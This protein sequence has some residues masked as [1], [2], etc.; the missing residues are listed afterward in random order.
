MRISNNI[1]IRIRNILWNLSDCSRIILAIVTY[2]YCFFHWFYIANFEWINFDIW[3][4]WMIMIHYIVRG[5]RYARD[6]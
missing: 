2:K 4:R 5:G 6:E 1:W 3:K